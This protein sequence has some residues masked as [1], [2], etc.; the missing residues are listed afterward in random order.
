MGFQAPSRTNKQKSQTVSPTCFV[1]LGAM[2]RVLRCAKNHLQRT[3]REE[4]QTRARARSFRSCDRNSSEASRRG[5]HFPLRMFSLR[6]SDRG[7]CFARTFGEETFQP[8]KVWQPRG[9]GNV[10]PKSCALPSRSQSS[11][12]SCSIRGSIDV[13]LTRRVCAVLERS[14]KGHLTRWAKRTTEWTTIT[15]AYP[16]DGNDKLAM[17]HSPSA[18]AAGGP[19]GAALGPE[20]P[21]YRPD[22]RR[23]GATRAH[24]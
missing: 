10:A 2:S 7:A 23:T 24:H 14:G 17:G 13:G 22:P 3:C 11:V 21:H 1:L 16:A 8:S 19:D 12:L 5:I 18:P 6:Q 20:Q 15:P 4:T 9:G